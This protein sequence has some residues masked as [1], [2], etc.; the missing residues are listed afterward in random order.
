MQTV[1]QTIGEVPVAGDTVA[2]VV[3]QVVEASPVPVSEV[4]N[5]LAPVV[6]AVA[7]PLGSVPSL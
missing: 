4:E 2:P 1:V 3:E 7:A 5:D 6:D